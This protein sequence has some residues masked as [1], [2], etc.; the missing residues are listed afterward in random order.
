MPNRDC[1]PVCLDPGCKDVSIYLVVRAVLVL[2]ATSASLELFRYPVLQATGPRSCL[3]SEQATGVAQQEST[4][5][6]VVD[7]SARIQSRR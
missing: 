2:R 3:K 5:H 6:D 4:N 7:D 1:N